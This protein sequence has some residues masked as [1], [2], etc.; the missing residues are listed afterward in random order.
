MKV[1]NRIGRRPHWLLAGLLALALVAVAG[2]GPRPT[3]PRGWS[4]PT[5]S[6]GKVYVGTMDGRLVGVDI[7]DGKLFM[8]AKLENGAAVY[9]SPLVSG[10]DVYAGAYIG[11]GTTAIGRVYTFVSGENQTSVTYPAP[12]KVIGGVVGNLVA[13]T[14]YFGSADNK[15]YAVTDRLQ[16]MW[17]FTTGGKIWSSPAVSGGTVYV[18]SFDKKLY[19]LS[20]ADGTKQWE[21]R[22]GG[23]IMAT[24]VV[25]GGTVYVGSFDR[26]L[27][28]LDAATGAKKWEYP[29]E[30]WFWAAP[31]V[32]SGT[33]YAVSINGWLH[34]LDAD[35]GKL[36]TKINLGAAVS[37]PPVLVGNTLVM[38]TEA[39]AVL[40]V[41]VSPQLSHLEV[42]TLASIGE[43][44]SA[45]IGVGEGRVFVHSQ[46]D[47]LYSVDLASA[48]KTELPTK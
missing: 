38:V 14:T 17:S 40:T 31:V 43:K 47:K 8:N 41:D 32:S 27:Y 18:G 46:A 13:G 45:A 44:V 26:K 20:A 7:A 35:A 33:V 3:V 10:T 15:V 22:T 1:L 29:A 24:P 34:V 19:A 28:A 39:G 5:V 23:A 11:S 48:T 21:F 4:G 42:K 25:D 16:D 2:C 36:V 37:A 9:G 6:G 12:G 30:S